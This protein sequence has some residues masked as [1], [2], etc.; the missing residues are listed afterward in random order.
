MAFNQRKVSR[1]LAGDSLINLN[2][3]HKL[4]IMPEIG[5]FGGIPDHRQGVRCLQ[6]ELAKSRS[7]AGARGVT[8]A[9]YE[10][11]LGRNEG[12]Q[13]RNTGDR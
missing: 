12:R 4:H 11:S 5:T 10:L 3:P 7:R 1:D 13:L 8:T 6:V 9:T 2:P